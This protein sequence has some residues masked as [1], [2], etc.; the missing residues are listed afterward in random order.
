MQLTC[1]LSRIQ[2]EVKCKWQIKSLMQF[3]IE[4]SPFPQNII[5]SLSPPHSMFVFP[6]VSRPFSI[7]GA[8]LHKRWIFLFETCYTDQSSDKLVPFNVLGFLFLFMFPRWKVGFYC[9]IREVLI[10]C[11]E[12]Q[13]CWIFLDETCYIDQWSTLAFLGDVEKLFLLHWTEGIQ[14]KWTKSGV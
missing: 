13:K 11:A 6:S 12:L 2:V 14:W 10:S 7:S 8:E 5:S 1:N 9:K 4:F 3:S